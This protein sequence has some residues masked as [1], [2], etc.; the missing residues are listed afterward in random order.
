MKKK[1][2]QFT[3]IELL[4]VIAVIAILASLLLPAL[5]K[6][7]N[8]A[9]IPACANNQKQIYLA[10]MNYVD[11][12][13]GYLSPLGLKWQE[14]M[15]RL[16]EYTEADGRPDMIDTYYA[17]WKKLQNPYHCPATVLPPDGEAW[18]NSDPY[19]QSTDFFA[20]SYGPTMKIDNPSDAAAA[21]KCGG[22]QYAYKYTD[23]NGTKGCTIAKKLNHVTDNSVILIEKHFY[24]MLGRSVVPAHYSKASYTT[25][26][27]YSIRAFYA[28]A[29]K[30]HQQ[31]SNFLFKDGHIETYRLGDVNFN[32]DWQVQ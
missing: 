4:V 32:N 6:A 27:M 9:L 18:D 20:S 15:L 25:V 13:R 8:S 17:C 7:R 12:S 3:L 5:K 2:T 21:G 19:D 26:P 14:W 28:P 1:F 31:R 24:K 11:D 10:A 16:V 23:T 22:W 29:W 30:R